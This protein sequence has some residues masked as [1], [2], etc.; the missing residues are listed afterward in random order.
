MQGIIY[1]RVSTNRQ[2]TS[3]QVNEMMDIEGIEIKKVFNESISGYTKSIR[4]RPILQNA[5]EY[6]VKNGIEI[7][8]VSEISRLGRKTGEV[9]SLIE[10]LKGKNIKIF[11]KSL[12]LTLNQNGASEPVNKL[13]VTLLADLARMESEQLSYRIKSGLENRKRQGMA[14]GRKYGSIES[15]SK[16][17]NKHSRVVGYLKDGESV[18]WI[19]TKLKMSPTTIQKVR[20]KMLVIN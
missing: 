2:S 4:E 7:I 10:D 3:R 8:C 15:D 14:I 1:S 19:A 16:F 20:N 6:A 13:I 17:L 9:L 11:V 12:G 18:R 5:I